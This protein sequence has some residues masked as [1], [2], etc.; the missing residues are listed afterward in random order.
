V[1]PAG[2][3]S[4]GKQGWEELERPERAAAIVFTPWYPRF[5]HLPQH[6]VDLATLPLNNTCRFSAVLK[7]C[8]EERIWCKKSLLSTRLKQVKVAAGLT[9]S[10]PKVHCEHVGELTVFVFVAKC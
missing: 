7:L 8:D 1:L 2:A 6:T 3:H 9:D 5:A 4:H 10:I